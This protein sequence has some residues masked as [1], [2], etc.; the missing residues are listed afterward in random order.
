MKYI[1]TGLVLGHYWRFI[2]QP[3]QMALLVQRVCHEKGSGGYNLPLWLRRRPDK[4]T[5]DLISTVP[6]GLGIV[7]GLLD[8]WAR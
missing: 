4:E 2:I 7:S 8:S 3:W 6:L 1:C 5:E